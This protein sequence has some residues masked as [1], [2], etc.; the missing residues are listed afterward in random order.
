VIQRAALVVLL[1]IA[2]VGYGHPIAHVG[3]RS[4][5]TLVARGDLTVV[6]T[7]EELERPSF[8]MVLQR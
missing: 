6:K 2:A 7:I 5:D 3:N 1:A 8:F 4:V